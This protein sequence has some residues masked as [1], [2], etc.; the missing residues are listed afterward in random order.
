MIIRRL[1]QLDIPDIIRLGGRMHEESQ[2]GVLAYSPERVADKCY[3]VTV[4][5]H[6]FGVVAYSDGSIIGMMGGQVYQ[7]DY[8]DELIA[9]DILVYVSPA[10]RGSMAFI[11]MVRKY[12]AWAKEQGAK[13]VFL[14]QTTGVNQESVSSLYQRLGF[15]PV[16]GQFCLE[17]A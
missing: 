11:K 8:G 17:V 2:Y 13:L 1:E 5:L 16:G 10:Y 6:M 14:S 3:Q 4:N 12:V 9:T 7:Y 15:K